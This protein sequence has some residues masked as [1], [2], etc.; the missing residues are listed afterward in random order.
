MFETPP[1][2]DSWEFNSPPAEADKREKASSKDVF[3]TPFAPI[4][5]MN[6]RITNSRFLSR[7][8]PPILVWFILYIFFPPESDTFPRAIAP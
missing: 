1:N 7:L 6:G 4:R 8:N 2:S 5:T 3:P